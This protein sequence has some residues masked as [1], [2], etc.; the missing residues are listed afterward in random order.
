MISVDTN[1]ALDALA[2][3]LG[4]QETVGPPLETRER[5]NGGEWSPWALVGEPDL[6]QGFAVYRLAALPAHDP[7]FRGKMERSWRI[8]KKPRLPVC[9]L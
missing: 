7:T 4:P 8:A 5:I 9:L 3:L 2:A 1:T 6:A